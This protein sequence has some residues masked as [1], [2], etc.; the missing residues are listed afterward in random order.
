MSKKMLLYRAKL[1]R[2]RALREWKTNPM[3]CLL[4]IGAEIL[5]AKALK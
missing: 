4:I 3:A 1:M 5:E 2:R